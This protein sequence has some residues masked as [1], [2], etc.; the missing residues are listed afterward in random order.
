M[1]GTVIVPLDGS[2]LAERALV[3]GLSIADKSGAPLLLFRSLP[4]GAD[5]PSMTEARN[6]L[7]RVAERLTGRVQMEV[8]RGRAADAIVDMTEQVLQPIIVMTTHGRGGVHRWMT[9][10]VAD[11][12]V[13]LSHH[14]VLLVRVGHEVPESLTMRRILVPLDGT[15]YSEQAL[16]YAVEIARL[17]ECEL[18]LVRV[19]DTPSA[20]GILSRNMETAI[21]GDILDEI[22]AGMRSEV[23][24]YL[25]AKSRE[26]AEQRINVTTRALEG[27]PGQTLVD[28]ERS[29]LFELVVMATAGRAGFSRVVFGSVAERMLKLGRTPVMM[30]RP[31]DEDMST[32]LES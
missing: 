10:S 2:D 23:D 1:I 16:S 30:V 28:Y 18:H 7:R 22:I 5:E 19:V 9:G 29:G 14:P 3:Y 21:T 8:V 17:Y 12:V 20:Y 6:Y 32:E 13:R 15:P 25:E 24:A 4:Y 26:L 27:Y 31:S 11:K